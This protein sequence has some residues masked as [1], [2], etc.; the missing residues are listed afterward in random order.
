MNELTLDKLEPGN[1]A[2]IV[3][4]EARGPARRRIAEM[5]LCPGADITMV[6]R[7][8][9]NDPVEFTVRGYFISLRNS[10]ASTVVVRTEGAR[11]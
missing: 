1:R 5:G 10:E 6:R 9:M 11:S 2:I 4:V 8:P 3:R 7:A